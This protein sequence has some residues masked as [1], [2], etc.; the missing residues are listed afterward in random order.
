MLVGKHY[1]NGYICDDIEQGIA[2]FQQR[3]LDRDPMII[4]VEQNVQTP[5]GPRLQQLRISMFWLNGLQYELIQP[6]VDEANVY[7]NA[8]SNGGPLRFHHICLRV[9]DWTEFRT[10]VDRQDFPVVMER[11]LGP[12]SLRFAYLDAR[13]V[14]GHYLE[15]TCMTDAMWDQ[16]A[17]L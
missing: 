11:D 8:P 5:A 4:P 17:N 16:M 6:I 13:K 12:D 2:L 1:Q 10:A 7:A 9:P 3:G 14:F 15:Y